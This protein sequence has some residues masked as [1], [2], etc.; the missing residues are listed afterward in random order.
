MNRVKEKPF[1]RSAELAT[2]SG[3]ST[4][5]LRHYEHKG[6]LAAG[7]SSNG[8]REYPQAAEDRVRL[9]QHALAVGFSL[10]ELARLMKVRD[11]GGLPCQEVRALARTKLESLES[12]IRG[13]TALKDELKL[14]LRKWDA[15]L[16]GTEKGRRAG[17]LDMLAAQ[18]IPVGRASTR[19]TGKAA[20]GR[21]RAR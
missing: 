9:V 17:L 7:R 6:L 15:R 13:L 8:Y 10:D 21:R 19:L 1:L 14:M 2:L 3:V 4:D 20:R 11:S 5:T 18:P 12:Q 16:A